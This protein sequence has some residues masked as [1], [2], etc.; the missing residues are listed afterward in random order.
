MLLSLGS[1][2]ASVGDIARRAVGVV[3]E[4]FELLRPS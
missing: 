4:H 3:G 1:Y 2:S